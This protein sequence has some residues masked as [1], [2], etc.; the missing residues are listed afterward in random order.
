MPSKSQSE[1]KPSYG[2]A[3]QESIRE[4][5]MRKGSY[6]RGGSQTNRTRNES[7]RQSDD[8]RPNRSSFGEDKS[9]RSDVDGERDA[10]SRSK[11]M[12]TMSPSDRGSC[13]NA[14]EKQTKSGDLDKAGRRSDGSNCNLES[15][16]D[17]E[18]VETIVNFSKALP[19]V[20]SG[21][22][23][24]KNSSFATRMHLVSG[25]VHL[26]DTLMRDQTSTEMATLKITQ[27]LRLEQTKLDEVGRRVS[28]SGDD[29]FA[30]L[31]AMCRPI[32]SVEE[33]GVEANIQQ[34]PLRNL[35]SYLKQ[36]EAAG[37]IS[38]PPNPSKD[39]QNIGVLHAFPPC[40]FGYD[41]LTKRAPK[42]LSETSKDDH[43][44]VIVV[45]GA[46]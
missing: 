35:I 7:D 11:R 18:N 3:E 29:G 25:N 26:V 13:K 9:H 12:R 15:N 30:V 31:L 28:T 43:L 44:V 36:K 5:E 37:V 19:V 4:R 14:D 23:V 6:G 34:R 1:K 2:M 40:A 39:K 33:T 10:P 20:W 46:V 17:L 42:L 22:L 27:R 32:D 38:L 21:A 45:R 41:F 24:L 16:I 8:R